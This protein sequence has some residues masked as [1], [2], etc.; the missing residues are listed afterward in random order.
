MLS[1]SNLV[2]LGLGKN[3]KLPKLFVE[4]C[5]VFGDSRLDNAEIVI[6]HFLTLRRLCSEKS[7]AR[8]FQILALLVHLLIN[9]E[10]FLLRSDR[11][12]N[13][14]YIVIAKELEDS[15]CLLVKSLH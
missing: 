2:M 1:G 6:I 9:K 11:G 15:H 7:S 3:A 13:T 10:I 8:K 12:A 4:V 5:H 14:L